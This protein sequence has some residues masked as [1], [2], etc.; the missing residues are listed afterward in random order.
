M[1]SPQTILPTWE[2]WGS[3]RLRYNKGLIIS[4][5]LAFVLY[6]AVVSAF[7][8]SMPDAEFTVFTTVF[9][10]IGYLIMMAIA[11]V[12]FFLGPIAESIINPRDPLRFRVITFGLGY[13][14]S[15]S[16]PFLIP[17]LFLVQ[18]FTAPGT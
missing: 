17:I 5:L 11:N 16:M 3:Q 9:Q 4:G 2:W 6:V 12:L 15:A 14:G 13:W 8:K 7:S 1:N 18:V 10:G